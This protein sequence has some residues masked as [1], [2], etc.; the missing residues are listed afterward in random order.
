MKQLI[1]AQ[2]VILDTQV[3]SHAATGKVPSSDWADFCTCLRSGFVHC[4]SPLVVVELLYG[5][6]AGNDTHFRLNQDKLRHLFQASNASIFLPLPGQFLAKELFS[7]NRVLPS[8]VETDY[9]LCLKLAIGAKD[10]QQILA[11]RLSPWGSDQ[12]YTLDLAKL[13][14][15]R[16]AYLAKYIAY[17]EGFRSQ[18]F[19]FKNERSWVAGALS[20]LGLPH[21]GEN[22]RTL[23]EGAD[24]WYCF[25]KFIFTSVSG[26]YNFKKHT[27]DLVDGQMLQYLCDPSLFLVT[28]D[29]RLKKQI[30]MC[31]QA[32]R[33]LTPKEF[34]SKFRMPI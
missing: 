9:E 11:G 14:K 33:I 32:D 2:R 4:I 24:A 17:L 8:E 16:E 12:Q 30:L 6:Y 3:C 18:G 23:L 7:V 20:H 21:M 26:N 27:S 10:K 1:T 15:E 25:E 31:K 5:L 19:R 13:A 22:E 28:S 34:L 29:A